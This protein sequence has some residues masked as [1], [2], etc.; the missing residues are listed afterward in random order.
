MCHS[1]PQYLVIWLPPMEQEALLV[2]REEAST[3]IDRGKEDGQ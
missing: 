2:G 3:G 1:H